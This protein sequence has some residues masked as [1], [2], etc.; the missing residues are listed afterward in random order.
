[1]PHLIYPKSNFIHV[2]K[3]GLASIMIIISF[4]ACSPSFDKQYYQRITG[5]DFPLKYKV[6]E[7]FDNGE[8]LTGTLLEVD[9]LELRK[10]ILLYHFDTFTIKDKPYLTFVN[11]P[12]FK[13]KPPALTNNSELYFLA[14][15]K[16][17]NNW[18]Y[19][20]DMKTKRIWAVIDYPDWSGR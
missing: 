6:L 5:I 10:F 16:D 4:S 9:S 2:L 14:K 20:V 13:L 11:N 18:T 3:V 17:K 8:W 19:L 12:Y 7:T 15:S 1:M